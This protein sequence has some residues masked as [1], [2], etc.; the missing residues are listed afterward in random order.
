MDARRITKEYRLTHW[1]GIVRDRTESGLNVREFC[2]REE[3]CENTY[4]YWQR[5]LREAVCGEPAVAAALPTPGGWAPGTLPVEIGKCRVTVDR[6]TD[7]D[8]L[9]KV[10]RVLMTL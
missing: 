5:K 2:G 4:C 6:D 9:A 7:D 8:L 10:C 3:I 1:S